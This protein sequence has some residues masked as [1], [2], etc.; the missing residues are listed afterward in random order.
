MRETVRSQARERAGGPAVG[1]RACRG[2]ARAVRARAIFEYYPPINFSSY[3]AAAGRVRGKRAPP[4]SSAH[5]LA[6]ARLQC[7]SR[8]DVI[9]YAVVREIPQYSL[10]YAPIHPHPRRAYPAILSNPRIP[11][12]TSCSISASFGNATSFFSI[13]CGNKEFGTPPSWWLRRGRGREGG[14]REGGRE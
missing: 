5:I 13:H 12:S 2:R 7:N 3:G 8:I 4:R 10:A 14:G 11:S 6:F 1:R 9:I